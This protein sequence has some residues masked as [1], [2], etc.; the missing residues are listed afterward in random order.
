M[1]QYLAKITAYSTA[2]ENSSGYESGSNNPINVQYSKS[3]SPVGFLPIPT[4]PDSMGITPVNKQIYL[5]AAAQNTQIRI[6]LLAQVAGISS[7]MH[8]TIYDDVIAFRD[9]FTH[10]VDREVLALSQFIK[11]IA[12]GDQARMLTNQTA[13]PSPLLALEEL[14]TALIAVRSAVWEDLTIRSRDVARLKTIIIN[15]PTPALVIAYDEYED[16]AREKEIVG[17][18]KITHPGFVPQGSLRVLSA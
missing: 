1:L 11:I 8:C 16:A 4:L 12:V 2:V 5:N 13:K 9:K 18:N 3:T 14:H 15:Q 6:A 17:R 7:L 10:A